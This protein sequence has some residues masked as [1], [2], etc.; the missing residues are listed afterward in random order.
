VRAGTLL[1]FALLSASFL[2]AQNPSSPNPE[3]MPAEDQEVFVPWWTLQPGWHTELE[4][5]NNEKGRHIEIEPILR[6][7]N[8]TEVRLPKVSNPES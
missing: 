8:G 5:R 7:A 6:L 1:A 3:P 2:C 4:I